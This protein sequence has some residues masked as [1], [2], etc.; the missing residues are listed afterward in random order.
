MEIGWIFPRKDLK[1]SSNLKQS[2]S[3]K[4]VSSSS[5]A[6]FLI[7]GFHVS[8]NLIRK[9]SKIKKPDR[10]RHLLPHGRGH[11][12]VT[13][14]WTLR[15]PWESTRDTHQHIPPIY[16]LYDGWQRAIWGNI[17]GTTARVPKGALNF[18]LIEQPRKKHF[19]QRL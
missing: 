17:W 9:R 12:V 15:Y 2:Q 19:F 3:K 5:G 8:F 4:M 18:T 14:T 7:P 16:G 11:A 1:K 10:R 13:P 6:T